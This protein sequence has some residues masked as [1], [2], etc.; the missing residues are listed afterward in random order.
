MKESIRQIRSF[1]RFYTQKL[2]ILDPQLLESPYSLTEIRVLFEIDQHQLISVKEI[3]ELLQLKAHFVNQALKKL[4]NDQLI[5]QIDTSH[6]KSGRFSISE[7][8][9][10]VMAGLVSKMEQKIEKQINRL[11][12]NDRDVLLEA[13]G[14]IYNLMADTKVMIQ[15]VVYRD[16]LLP[17]DIGYM[18]YLHGL[19]YSKESAYNIQFEGYVAQTFYEF[20]ERYDPE[21]DRIWLA[22]YYNRIIGS[23]AIVHHSDTRAQ[24]RWFLVHPSFRG[25]GIGKKLYQFA[26]D[27]CT[28]K[29]YESI[30]LYTTDVQTVAI[31]MYEKSGFKLQSEKLLQKWGLEMKEIVYELKN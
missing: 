16:E 2:G 15:D 29:A 8:G 12:I 1:N 5:Y 3:I 14:S 28:E 26:M 18:I 13:M 23:I 25:G 9:R 24:L 4:L 21:N 19:L 20:L 22:T 31:K 10:D 17:G 30:F 11:P 7:K 27:Y 6:D